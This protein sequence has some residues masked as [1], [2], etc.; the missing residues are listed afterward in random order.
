MSPKPEEVARQDID[1]LLTS[2]GWVVQDYKDVHITAAQGVAVRE[3]CCTRT[4]RPSW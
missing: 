2:C 3:F 1:E 4:A